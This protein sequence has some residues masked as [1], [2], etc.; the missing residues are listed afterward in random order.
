L[1]V[2]TRSQAREAY[3]RYRTAVDLAQHQ[4]EAALLTAALQD[5]TQL[6]YNG[7]LQSTWDLLASAR[8]RLQSESAAHLAQRDAWLAYIDLQAVLSGA[9]VDFSSPNSA[10]G[11][12]A[13]AQP[14][15]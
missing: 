1:A 10:A 12:T 2:A 15:H 6:R 14:G 9:V 8:A 7:M 5:E 3:F 13:A 4:R 11:T